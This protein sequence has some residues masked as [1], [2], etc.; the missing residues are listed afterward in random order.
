MTATTTPKLTTRPLRELV[1]GVDALYLS[2]TGQ[3]RPQIIDT[4]ETIRGLVGQVNQ[5]LPVIIDGDLTL[6]VAPH[7]WASTAT[8]GTIP[9]PASGSP[10]AA[11][12]PPYGS[13]PA[14]STSTAPAPPPP[15]T[16]SVTR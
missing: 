3:P 7:G 12:S 16:S 4:L 13:S 8:A 6:V 11:T 5:P 1:S 2:G 14:P 15:S 10:P 9:P